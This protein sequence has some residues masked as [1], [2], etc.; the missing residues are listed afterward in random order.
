MGLLGMDVYQDELTDRIFGDLVLSN[1]FSKLADNIYFGANNIKDFQRIF[2][3]ILQRCK[4]SDLRIKPSKE[5]LNVQNSDI[6][7]LH[8]QKGKL[9][10]S[11]H[12][13]DPLAECD[14]PQTVR[15]LR[16]WLG[17]GYIFYK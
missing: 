7:G 11:Q 14:P 5:S 2:H 6:L 17:Q 3:T 1:H 15:G 13:L 8:W 9:S 16:S 10:P 4:E 12:K